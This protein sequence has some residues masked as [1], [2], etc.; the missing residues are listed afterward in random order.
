MPTQFSEEFLK[1]GNDKIQLFKGG[2]GDP[3]LILH[4]AGGNRGPLRYAQT[5]ANH[6]TVYLPSHPGF[7]KSD[8]PEWI[9]TIQDLA[10]FYTW[11]QEIHDLEDVR[12]IGF[13][14]GGWLAAEIAA[15]C[16]H[17]FSS[18]MLVNAVGIKP[19]NSEIADI[20][21]ISPAQIAELTFHD[22]E[23]VPEYHQIFEETPTAE[24]TDM[25]ERDR[26]MAVRVC[27]RPYMHDPRLPHLLQRV[28]I[29][30]SIVW[31]KQDRIVPL[32]CAE[33]YHQTIKGSELKVID[34]C[35]HSPQI[36]KPDEFVRIALD[37]FS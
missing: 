5:L 37:F 35:G 10:S 3:L 33:L 14:M 15:T 27:W 26:E 11:L 34:G 2:S 31:G 8:R 6:F 7:G 16:R 12:A 29:P 4:G 21:I 30:T 19:Q 23:Q 25:A 20:F 9:E 36:E 17:A 13:S 28:S 1:V 32:E 22:P 24:Q 18:L